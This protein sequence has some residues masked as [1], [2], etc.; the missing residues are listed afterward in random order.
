MIRLSRSFPWTLVV[1]FGVGFVL[2]VSLESPDARKMKGVSLAAVTSSANTSYDL[3]SQKYDDEFIT[4]GNR[5]LDRESSSGN[6]KSG[7]QRIQE[8]ISEWT[9]APLKSF[10]R[11]RL[12]TVIVANSIQTGDLV[13][14][15]HWLSSAQSEQLPPDDGDSQRLLDWLESTLAIDEEASRPQLASVAG[16]QGSTLVFVT[17]GAF[18]PETLTN[19]YSELQ[20]AEKAVAREPSVRHRILRMSWELLFGEIIASPQYGRISQAELR[21]DRGLKELHDIKSLLKVGEPGGI[22]EEA[23]LAEDQVVALHLDAVRLREKKL[24]EKLKDV[25]ELSE[26][27]L[28][29]VQKLFRSYR[30]MATDVALA[31]RDAQLYEWNSAQLRFRNVKGALDA[32]EALIANAAE[33]KIKPEFLFDPEPLDAKPNPDVLPTFE[34]TFVQH[35]R[36]VRSLAALRLS[37]G[38]PNAEDRLELIKPVADELR[39]DGLATDPVSGYVFGLV[40][41]RLAVDLL[42][43]DPADRQRRADAKPWFEL[44]KQ[45]LSLSVEKLVVERKRRFSDDS[46]A[47]AAING[48]NEYLGNLNVLALVLPANA[49]VSSDE[50]KKNAEYR[51]SQLVDRRVYLQEAQRLLTLGDSIGCVGVLSQAVER[52]ADPDVWYA[53]VRNSLRAKM[54]PAVVAKRLKTLS[55]SDVF[56]ADDFRMP[57]LTGLVELESVRRELAN[58]DTKVLFGA[59]NSAQR[60]RLRDALAPAISNFRTATTRGI[61]DKQ[62]RSMCQAYLSLCG[63]IQLALNTDRMFKSPFA[64]GELKA[65]AEEVI[66]N[67]KGRADS[68]LDA[69]ESI[70]AALQSRGFLELANNPDDNIGVALASFAAANDRQAALPYDR[71]SIREFGSLIIETLRRRKTDVTGDLERERSLRRAFQVISAAGLTARFGTPL[72]L[73]EGLEHGLQYVNQSRRSGEDS[74]ASSLATVDAF[75]LLKE[76]DKDN[77]N[78]LK[79]LILVYQVLAWLDSSKQRIDSSQSTDGLSLRYDEAA[80]AKALQSAILACQPDTKDASPTLANMQQAIASAGT[81][82]AGYALIRAIDAKCA[83]FGLLVDPEREAWRKLMIQAIQQ[84]NKLFTDSVRERFPALASHYTSVVD[85][86]N[87]VTNQLED[88]RYLS[89]RLRLRDSSEMLQSAIVRHP[90]NQELWDELL[91]VGARR[92]VSAPL[93]TAQ[94]ATIERAA[95]NS[96]LTAFLEA[97]AKHQHNLSV[98]YFESLAL[99]RE[100]QNDLFG[101]SAVLEEAI[102]RI[103]TL[104]PAAISTLRASAAVL[105][106]KAEQV[107]RYQQ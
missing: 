28:Q 105:K 78:E 52:H 63:S 41:E 11:F 10:Q 33:K 9:Q 77:P 57:F 60:S 26:E 56:P 1:V 96:A 65:M 90:D 67:L 5:T 25:R 98:P 83:S 34:Q 61:L 16:I 51:L 38:L 85:Q 45:N 59:N 101:A 95:A 53:L 31:H 22:D 27:R 99:L 81:P 82:L 39:K 88:A 44:A 106:A 68:D 66:D 69:D 92:I 86:W 72:D 7:G 74:E 80:V 20:N 50:L 84:T 91:K 89:R 4:Q 19:A 47:M 23:R 36:V 18:P 97:C 62:Q 40:Y 6:R 103:P 102:T 3:F 30:Q 35:L 104:D 76:I 79:T 55:S 70:V 21:L 73:A 24:E 107:R 29:I 37:E 43:D 64:E 54:V 15:R 58:A 32:I 100:K 13:A 75:D 48:G 8:L 71:S 17:T 12:A 42:G 49:K 87:S 94:D 14:A 2:S 93:G 46:L